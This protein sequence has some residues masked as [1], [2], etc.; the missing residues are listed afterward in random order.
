MLT[1]LQGDHVLSHTLK[2]CQEAALCIEPGVSLQFLALRLH[3]F[4]DSGYA[5]LMIPFH[6]IEG[7]NDKVHNAEVKAAFCWILRHQH[8]SRHPAA[9]LLGVY[10]KHSCVVLYLSMCSVV[11]TQDK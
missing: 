5:K 7:P 10:A 3:G 11:K 2:Q 1:H 4:D 8:F 6:T 9:V